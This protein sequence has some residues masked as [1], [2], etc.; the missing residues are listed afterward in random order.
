ML[1]EA[2]VRVRGQERGREG[3]G[4]Y[5]PLPYYPT[6]RQLYLYDF[7]AKKEKDERY[8]PRLSSH[9]SAPPNL[10]CCSYY[11]KVNVLELSNTPTFLL[12]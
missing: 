8:H 3:E 10:F 9:L 4:G 12:Y 2:R 7:A 1:R 11:R 5:P 6:T